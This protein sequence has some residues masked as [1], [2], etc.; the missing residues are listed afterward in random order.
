MKFQ[1][2]DNCIGTVLASDITDDNNRLILKS[3]IV[4][5]EK[6]INRL[7]NFGIYCIGVEDPISQDIDV[8]QPVSN[9]TMIEAASIYTNQNSIDVD[10]AFS[11][12]EKLVDEITCNNSAMS[13]GLQIIK[14]YDENTSLHSI[15]VA[16]LAIMF[17]YNLGLN[18]TKLNNLAV[19]GLLHD[20]GKT[21][22]PIEI[23]NKTDKLTPEEFEEIKKHPQYGWDILSEDIL[24]P[25]TI[26]AIVY[27]H[28]EN[29][30]GT[31]YP[32]HLENYNVYELAAIVHICDVFDALI[33]KRSY[34]SAFKYSD[35]I[36]YIQ[37]QSGK[38][39]SPYYTKYFFKFVPIF[40]TGTDVILSNN[41]K[42]IIVKNNLGDMTR[43]TVRLYSNM[44]EINLTQ[45]KDLSII[46]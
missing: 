38:M 34:K 18:I 17:G 43:P 13:N 45:R 25:A 19:G 23:L 30:D 29:W 31:G 8:T 46:S 32:R 41:E 26:K 11:I 4:L 21:K 33:S 39:F 10:K 20:I 14:V 28:H 35:T 36:Q 9:K 16:I 2:L 5:T 1:T 24:M 6:I 40:H 42:A 22:V 3:G 37:S 44:E 12:A 7:R 27:Q 15:N